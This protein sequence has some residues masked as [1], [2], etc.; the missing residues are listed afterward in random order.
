MKKKIEKK[1]F[2]S[3]DKCIWIVCIELSPQRREYLSSAVN[4]LTKSLQIFHGTKRDFSLSISF[5][6][7]NQYG[8]RTGI[9][10]ESVFRRVYHA[11]CGGVL[12]NWSF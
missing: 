8:K 7:I 2:G 1:F 10:T 11:A 12:S 5:I 3:W 6:V 9:K 4:V